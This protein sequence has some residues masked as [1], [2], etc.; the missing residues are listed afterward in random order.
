MAALP[1]FG[2]PM[3]V[4]GVAR[5]MCGKVETLDLSCQEEHSDKHAMR[6]ATS[7]LIDASAATLVSLR[8]LSHDVSVDQICDLCALSTVSALRPAS[9]PRSSAAFPRLACV[10]VDVTCYLSG[11][12]P[13]ASLEGLILRAILANAPRCEFGMDSWKPDIVSVADFAAVRV[14]HLLVNHWGHMDEPA[15]AD[16]TAY[17]RE[18]VA[19]AAAHAPLS[20]LTLHGTPLGDTRA[21]ALDALVDLAVDKAG[22]PLSSFR[23]RQVALPADAAPGLTR[24]LARGRLA[25]LE[26]SQNGAGG[27]RHGVDFTHALCDALRASTSLTRLA[28]VSVGLWDSLAA[29]CRVSTA[30][31]GH[32]TLVDLRLDAN[33]AAPGVSTAAGVALAAIFAANAG[34]LTVFDISAC[35]LGGGGM[36]EVFGGLARNTQLTDFKCDANEVGEPVAA[37]AE[38][39][40]AVEDHPMLRWLQ[41]GDACLDD[42][43]SRKHRV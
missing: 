23:L 15:A 2:L 20:Q 27:A 28:L 41:S 19:A 18:L 31:A 40:A 4:H 22:A 34:A 36:R 12:G 5:M 35:A 42:V 26:V 37:D 16:P 13:S 3:L 1:G 17:V 39:R 7:R 8:W 32:K 38:V 43:V 25:A 6:I 9:V 24:L 30:V 21:D 29:G 11:D 33:A 10:E 14:R